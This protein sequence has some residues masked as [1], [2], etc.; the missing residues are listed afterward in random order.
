VA[1][2]DRLVGAR[3]P[4]SGIDLA[5]IVAGFD[6][7]VAAGPVEPL[8]RGLINETFQ[9][10]A[11]DAGY[12]LQ[13]INT[14]VFADPGLIMSNLVRLGEHLGRR[15]STGLQIPAAIPARD[16]SALV[17]GADGSVWRMLELVPD[18]LT[19]ARIE[20][21]AQAGEIGRALGRFHRLTS[22]LPLDAV[23][24][25]LPGFHDTPAY[26]GRLL[27]VSGRIG[28]DG[29]DPVV[30][31]C[32]AAIA[33]RRALASVLADARAAGRLPLRVVHGDPKADNFLFS[34]TDG[35]AL[36][37]IDLDT[38]QPGLVHDD[39]GDCLRSCCNRT[40][41]C[42]DGVPCAGFDLGL[43]EAILD[44]YAAEMGPVLGADEI[45]LIY[46]AIRL[47]PFELA[48][49]FLTDHLEGDPW[50]KVAYRGQNLHKAR[51][52]LALVAAIEAKADRIRALIAQAFDRTTATSREDTDDRLSR[53]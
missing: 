31:D 18:A 24:V 29:H 52:Q 11:G 9:V 1:E 25:T 32:L 37:L 38:V 39:L 13:R 6:L 53:G 47:L 48:L 30:T 19:L 46:D 17:R 7:P 51:V 40:G 27:A 44:A 15:G 34:R 12:V 43:C 22:D 10:H 14:G 36:A 5:A 33:E 42:P 41:E 49:R 23:G 35:R 26:L 45:D 2:P 20:T 21:T 4:G 3:A 50:F 8:G 28:P 16:G